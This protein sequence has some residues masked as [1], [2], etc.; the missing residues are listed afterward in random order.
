MVEK[1]ENV[2]YIF[3]E[4]GVTLPSGKVLDKNVA[5]SIL[6]SNDLL[7]NSSKLD[8]VAENSNNAYYNVLE[9]NICIMHVEAGFCILVDN[10]VKV[11][12]EPDAVSLPTMLSATKYGVYQVPGDK[13]YRDWIKCTK[14]SRPIGHDIQDMVHGNGAAIARKNGL[15]LDHGAETCNELLTNCMYKSDNINNGSHRVCVRINNEEDLKG[16]IQKI[17]AYDSNGATGFFL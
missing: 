17:K 3:G 13:T 1:N 16:L 14:N 4:E 11:F 9:T 10:K 6:C 8:K 12:N 15:S 5:T 2:N 7:S